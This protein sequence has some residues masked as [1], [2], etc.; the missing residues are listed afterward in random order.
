VPG[1]YIQYHQIQV[2][3]NGR[4][5]G[6][7]QPTA[8]A[9]AGFSERSGRRIESGEHQPKYGQER[10][11]RTR[12]D[13]FAEVWDS[14]LRP[15]LEREPQLEPTTLYEDLLERYPGQF[16]GTLRTLQRRVEDW[17]ALH[18]EAPEVMFALKHDPGE[19]GLSDFTHLKGIEITIAGEP[20]AHLLYHYRLAYSG[21]QYVQVI[22]GGESFIGLSQGMQNAFAASGGVPKQHRTDSLS[23]AYRNLGSRTRNPQLT[24]MYEEVCAHYRLQATRNNLGIAHENGAIEASHGHFKRRL[25]QALLLRGSYNFETVSEYQT[26]IEAVIAKMNAKCTEKFTQ[27]QQVLQP[28]PKYRYPDYEVLSAKVSQYSTLSIRCVLYSVPDRLVGKRLSVHLY[29]DRLVGYFNQHKVVELPRMHVHG[30]EAHR[31]A[32]CINY[33]HLAESLRRKPRAFLYCAW[34][35]EILPNA[36]WRELWSRLKTSV[37]PDSAARVMVEALYIAATQN[38]EGGVLN[39]LQS[40]FRRGSL[41]LVGLQR[42]FQLLADTP[43]PPAIE[44]QQHNLALYDDLLHHDSHAVSDSEPAPQ[45]SSPQPHAERVATSRTESH[46]G[47]LVL[48]PVLA[49]TVRIGDGQAQPNSDLACDFRSSIALGKIVLQL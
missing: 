20:L 2:Y 12:C 4:E 45:T 15:K 19:L 22:Q 8:A 3:M 46:S 1:K 9:I 29:H 6:L 7:N 40:Q 13:P 24:R 10:T 47:A 37:D 27:E 34:Q 36:D 49:G 16:E 35:Q 48:R 38:N 43:A 30:S 25:K 26:F 11:W 5:A 21:W 31:R 17:K 33:R 42:H 14:E 23:A 41:T 44:V 18:G 39:F 32:R 28:L